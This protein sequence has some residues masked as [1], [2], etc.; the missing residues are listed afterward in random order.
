MWLQRQNV[1]TTRQ[2]FRGFYAIPANDPFWD[3]R[4][5]N[6]GPQRL[7]DTAVYLR[8]AMTLH[9]L[10]LRVGDQHFFRIVRRWAQTRAGDNVRTREF[11]R[12]AERVSGRNLDG[13]FD[14][15]L[16]TS[17]KPRV[18]GLAPFSTR[19]LRVT[20]FATPEKLTPRH[21]P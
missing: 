1:A 3:L 2:V 14:D 12:L 15:W 6:P 21:R 9:R 19:P 10:R 16:F 5:G 7:F 13:L 4:I 11:I 18:R 8:G 20:P 17:R